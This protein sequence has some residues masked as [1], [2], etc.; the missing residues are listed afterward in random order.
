[1]SETR[2]TPEPRPGLAVWKCMSCG[3]EF[4]P[5]RLL[6]LRCESPDFVAGRVTEGVIEEITVVR[7]VLGQEGWQPRRIAN[8]RTPNGPMLSVGLLDD[9]EVGQRIQ[10]LQQGTAPVGRAT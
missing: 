5:R 1:M 7:H 2:T 8:V 9:S 4:F 3:A 6:C 10:I